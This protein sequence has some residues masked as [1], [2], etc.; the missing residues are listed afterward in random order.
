MKKHK[1]L[2]AGISA[3]FTLA[4]LGSGQVQ[5]NSKPV[6]ITSQVNELI[7]QLDNQG[8]ARLVAI[9]P[10][11]IV[12][13]D[14]ILYTTRVQNNSA[15]ASD[16]ITI[17]NPIPPQVSYLAGTAQGDNC[18]IVYSVDGGGSW[19]KPRQLKVRMTDGQWRMAQ[20]SEYTHIRWQYQSALA[21]QQSSE[22][23]YQAKLK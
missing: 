5:A 14:R 4:L 13:G 23:S 6:I 9:T 19:G 1:V 22:I 10:D 15:Q 2:M 8:Q 12:P 20:A 21:A 18:D 7:K 17:T 16:N 11:S 3:A